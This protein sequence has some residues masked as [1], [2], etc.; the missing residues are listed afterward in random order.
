MSFPK[1]S[2]RKSSMAMQD[3]DY[4]N[5]CWYPEFN[6]LTLHLMLANP[7]T[8]IRS[9]QKGLDSSPESPVVLGHSAKC[10][11]SEL[12]DS[13]VPGQGAGAKGETYLPG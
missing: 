13:Q 8:Q 12:L 4:G 5:S 11:R 3:S 1:Q 7:V 9:A 10:P 6:D 2:N